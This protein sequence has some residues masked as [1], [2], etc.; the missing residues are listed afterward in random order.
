MGGT[1]MDKILENVWLAFAAGFGAFIVVFLLLDFIMMKMQ[2]LSLI[3]S[4]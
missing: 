4:G 1:E 2:G 3:F